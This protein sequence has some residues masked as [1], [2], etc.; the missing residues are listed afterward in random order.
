M[1][2]QVTSTRDGTIRQRSISDETLTIFNKSQHA[3]SMLDVGSTLTIR[4]HLTCLPHG[5][6][7]RKRRERADILA[8]ILHLERASSPSTTAV[9]RHQ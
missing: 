6:D 5:N 2:G 4:H 1:E 7:K 9:L 8:R 3:S